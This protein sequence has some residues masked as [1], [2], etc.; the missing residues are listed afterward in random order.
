MI[1]IHH[2]KYLR[3]FKGKSL[4]NIANETGHD[5]RTVKKYDEMDDFNEYVQRRKRNSK[6]DPYKP[7]IDEW[8][9]GDKKVKAKQ[10]HTAR[11][12]YKRLCEEYPDFSLSERTVRAYVRKKKKELYSNEGYLPLDHPGGEAQ[13]DFGQAQF[14]EKGKETTLHYLNLSFPYSN[15]GYFQLFRGENLECLLEGLKNIFEHMGKVPGRIWFDNLSPVVKEILTGGER[16]VTEKFYSFCLHYGFEPVFCNPGCGNEK[17]NVENKVGYNRR[18][19]FVPMPRIENL[20]DYNKKL[21]TLSGK[22]ME[23]HH[24]RKGKSIKELFLEEKEKMLPLN[25]KSLDISRLQKLKTDKYGML[26][27]ENNRYSVSPKCAEIE[28]WLKIGASEIEILDE[29]YK[30]LVKH[31]RLYG[32]NLQSLNW[33][34]YLETLSKRPRALKYT[35][36]YRE[37]PPIW[38]EYFE[39]CDYQEKKNSLKLLVKMLR[40]T[41]ME[42]ARHALEMSQE[43]ERC[44]AETIF[45]SY[46]RLIQKE[47]SPFETGNE[48]PRLQTYTT[49]FKEYDSLVGEVK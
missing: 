6:L 21:L 24:Y 2:I 16:K 20:E 13:A 48:V 36:F 32:H 25:E 22:D 9:E 47:P 49:D 39:A 1:Q 40:E 18:N 38:Q 41:D 27:F 5:F 31:P 3:E 30:V 37:L 14:I 45:L 44:N 33:Y 23:R 29:D 12:V 15:G 34:P 43:S 28:V 8:L 7:K 35:G 46:R 19:F 17:G 42:T 10:R 11:R 4:R 26:R